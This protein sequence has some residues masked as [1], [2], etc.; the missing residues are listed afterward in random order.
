MALTDTSNCDTCAHAV[1]GATNGEYFLACGNLRNPDGVAR[2]PI[3]ITL[4]LHETPAKMR[5][6]AIHDAVEHDVA[7]FKQ[8]GIEAARIGELRALGVPK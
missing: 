3:C 4:G 8:A 2:S 7:L 1:H 5:E 6:R